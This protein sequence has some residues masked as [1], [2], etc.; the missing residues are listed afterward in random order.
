MALTNEQERALALLREGLSTAEV[1]QRLGLSRPTVWRWQN[2][3]P[4][5]A[6]TAPANSGPERGPLTRPELA[7]VV[8]TLVVVLLAVL[9]LYLGYWA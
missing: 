5:F 4:E 3:L 2:E 8:V 9:F 7:R 1:A 6:A